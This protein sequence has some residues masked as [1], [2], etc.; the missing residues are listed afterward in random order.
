[1]AR[2]VLVGLFHMREEG[3]AA[4]HGGRVLQ[5]KQFHQR[6]AVAAAVDE[7][8]AGEAV[9]V[10]FVPGDELNA[11]GMLQIH[12][13]R[14][15]SEVDFSARA[16]CFLRQYI[17]EVVARNLPG[18]GPAGRE[19][20]PEGQIELFAVA[21]EARATLDGVVLGLQRGQHAGLFPMAHAQRQQALA[22]DE[23]REHG[24]L[25]HGHAMAL[26][27]EPCGGYGS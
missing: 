9:L 21:V 12:A 11:F 26:L 20:L 14:F 27:G 7:E 10:A 1:V 4:I 8:A 17:V 6:A 18:P 5:A 16:L 24:A 3:H 22:D 19:V 2:A 25:D 23:A 15:M 13:Q